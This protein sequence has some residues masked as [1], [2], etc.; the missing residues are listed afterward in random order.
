MKSR[1]RGWILGVGLL[2]AALL[3]AAFFSFLPKVYEWD[4]TYRPRQ[5]EPYDLGLFHSVLGS[6]FPDSDFIDLRGWAADTSYTQ[7]TGSNMITVGAEIVAAPKDR[8]RIRR[9]V[10]AGN[11]FFGSAT[12]YNLLFEEIMPRCADP[13]EKPLRMRTHYSGEIHVST[14]EN[15]AD[16]VAIQY[17]VRDELYSKQWLSASACP[18]PDVA[19][20]GHVRVDDKMY[21]NFLEI[22]Y[23]EGRFLLH[24]TPLAF[25]NY[26]FRR[27]EVFEYV[28]DVLSALDEGDVYFAPPSPILGEAPPPISAGPLQ[29]ILT[30]PPLRWAWFG[31]LAL[32]FLFVVNGIRRKRRPIPVLQKPGNHTLRFLEMKAGIYKKENQH[33]HIVELQYDLLKEFLK[34]RYRLNPDEYDSFI[35]MAVERL[36]MKEPY[37]RGF[38]Y[39]LKAAKQKRNLS[40]RELL[41]LDRSIQEFYQACP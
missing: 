6:Y 33:Q 20:L 15:P 34:E 10:A 21:P 16:S 11:T 26:H 36:E 38:F 41:D 9:Y 4:T 5:W 18:H 3:F 12:A 17:F 28:E 29:F 32:T 2:A 13:D 40:N 1:G 35:H 30:K 25:S 31:T 14:V 39:R 8:A 7:V 27:P 23:G 24:T 19:V 37:L 22:K